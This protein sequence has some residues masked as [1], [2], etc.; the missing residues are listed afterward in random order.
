MEVR[1]CNLPS[2]LALKIQTDIIHEVVGARTPCVGVVGTIISGGFSWL[3]GE[4]GCISDPANM[5]DVKVVL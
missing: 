1:L 4:Y 2:R 5:L 3:S